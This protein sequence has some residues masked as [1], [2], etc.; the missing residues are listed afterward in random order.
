MSRYRGGMDFED[1]FKLGCAGLVLVV[2]AIWCIAVYG[3]QKDITCTVESIDRVASS[4][5]GS[6]ARIY[7]K[8]CGVLT[9]KDS[10]MFLK[11]DSA[12]VQGRLKEG[13]KQTFGV[14][15][16]RIPFLSQFPNVLEVK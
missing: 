16:F 6:D 11:F 1:K 4:S 15:G 8:E 3:S 14:A 10:W 12:D 2:V 9:N 7:T 13:Q 5:G